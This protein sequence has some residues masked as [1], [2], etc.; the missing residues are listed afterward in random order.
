MSFFVF[1]SCES[2]IKTGGIEGMRKR[3]E[4]IINAKKNGEKWADDPLSI[5][6]KFF[7]VNYSFEESEIKMIKLNDGERATKLKI[8]IKLKS[9]SVERNSN[10][11]YGELYLQESKGIWKFIENS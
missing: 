9:K 5:I 2:E 3:N 10:W 11:A 6:Y 1:W 4:E 7:I 8:I